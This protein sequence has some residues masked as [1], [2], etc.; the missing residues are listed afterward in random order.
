M[1]YPAE[2]LM[3]V[4]PAD[5]A[6]EIKAKVLNKNIGFVRSGQTS[7]I[8]VES[9]PFTKYDLI[10][11]EVKS[12]SADAVDDEQLGPVYPMRFAMKTNRILVGDKWEKL[13]PGMS[14]TAEVKTG[15]RRAIEFFLSPLMCYRDEA[16][17]E[18]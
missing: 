9:F 14:V 5:A 1:V 12:I 11:G 6:L 7:E 13:T 4:V 16:L 18:R 10:D 8:K 2:R 17:R 15:K 3:V